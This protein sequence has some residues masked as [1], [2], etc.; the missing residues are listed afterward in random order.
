MTKKQ[1]EKEIR[2]LGLYRSWYKLRPDPEGILSNLKG[3]SFSLVYSR[4]GKSIDYAGTIRQVRKSIQD[5]L[6]RL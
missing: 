4:D 5:Q 2:F 1:F 6:G 3:L